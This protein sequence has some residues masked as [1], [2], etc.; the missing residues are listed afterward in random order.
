[1]NRTAKFFNRWMVLI[2][3]MLVLIQIPLL[4]QSGMNEIGSFEQT[5]P[6][7]WFKSS[8][9]GGSELQWASDEFITLGRSLK[10]NKSAT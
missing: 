5:D 4:G 6:S 9:P 3:T 10:I 7:Y 8:E 2:S 1:M